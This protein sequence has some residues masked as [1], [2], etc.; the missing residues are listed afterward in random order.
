MQALQ[1]NYSNMYICNEVDIVLLISDC[2]FLSYIIKVSLLK[3]NGEIESPVSFL[4]SFKVLLNLKRFPME[5][6][7]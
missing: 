7:D 4:N 1:I 3:S 5:G 6:V 2:F